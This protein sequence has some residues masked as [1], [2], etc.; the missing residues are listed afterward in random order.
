MSTIEKYAVGWAE[1]DGIACDSGVE[2]REGDDVEEMSHNIR[3]ANR[4]A[5]YTCGGNHMEIE[6]FF[7]D[8][9]ASRWRGQDRAFYVQT[10]EDGKGVQV[11]Q[12]Y[13]MPIQ[14]RDVN[15]KPRRQDDRTKEALTHRD[16]YPFGA[17]Y[18][19]RAG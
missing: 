3:S 17:S 19:P 14:T 8:Y 9:V 5:L 13:G 12:P 11:Y 16:Y 1:M 7:E 15:G 4:A 6:R 2:I 18:V 10:E